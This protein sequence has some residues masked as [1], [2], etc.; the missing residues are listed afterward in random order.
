MD[1]WDRRINDCRVF[2]VVNRPIRR[3]P[4]RRADCRNNRE[5]VSCE[6]V[7]NAPA[8]TDPKP[9]ALFMRGLQIRSSCDD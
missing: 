6:D 3:P 1:G 8:D 4:P 9:Y 7:K 2:Q 5:P